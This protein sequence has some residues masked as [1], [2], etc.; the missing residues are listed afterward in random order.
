MLKFLQRL[1]EHKKKVIAATGRGRRTAAVRQAEQAAREGDEPRAGTNGGSGDSGGGAPVRARRVR[2]FNQ[3]GN[4]VLARVIGFELGVL[5]LGLIVAAMLLLRDAP[6]IYFPVRAADS[7]MVPEVPLDEPAVGEDELLRWTA[8]RAVQSFS[9]DSDNHRR[10]FL[11]L[12]EH[13]SPSAW[14]AA[15]RRISTAGPR[16]PGPMQLLNEGRLMVSARPLRAPVIHRQGRVRD[17]YRWEVRVPLRIT[18][19]RPARVIATENLTVRMWIERIPVTE[20]PVP[21]Q[22]YDFDLTDPDGV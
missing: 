12:S 15:F 19:R 11:E 7:G 10:K 8:E 17:R 20:R 22:V 3:D 21:L 16:N 4:P 13:F 2:E 18:W 9:W 5:A 14:R 1:G 6:T